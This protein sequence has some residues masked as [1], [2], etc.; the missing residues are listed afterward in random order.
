MKYT[1]FCCGQLQTNCTVVQ[2]G[3]NCV[4]V[5]VPFGADEVINYVAQNNLHV[6]AVLLTHGHFDHCGG[7]SDLLQSCN[8]APVYVHKKDEELCKTAS[9]NAWGVVC[10]NCYPTHFLQEGRLQIEDFAFNVL[11]TPGHTGGSVV[12]LTEDGVLLSGDTLFRGSVGRTDFPESAPF[13][14][15]NSLKKVAS[16]QENYRVVCGHGPET[17]L[18]DEKMNNIYLRSCAL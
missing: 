6:V 17:T 16:L 10:N 12:F 15:K 4:V 18:N 14:M 3:K 5:D 7:V 11:E 8:D 9:Q 2:N 1:V 13:A